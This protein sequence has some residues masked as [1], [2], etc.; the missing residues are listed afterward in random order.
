MTSKVETRI[1]PTLDPD[2]YREIEGLNDETAPF[3]GEVINTYVDIYHVLGKLHDARALA[4]SNP[5][6]TPENRVLVVHREATKHRERVT[7]R[8]ASA[9][10]T[11]RDT[12]TH[13]ES[14]LS[15]P[16]AERAGHGTLNAEV[17]AHVKTM[18]RTAREAFMREAFAKDDEPTLAAILGGQSFLSGLTD[19]DHAHFVREYHSRKNPHL[20]RRLDVMNR[21]L[22]KLERSIPVVAKEFDKAVGAHRNVAGAIAHADQQMHDALKIEPIA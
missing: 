18:T 4:E 14:L 5:A 3:V 6:L 1:T 22:D 17:R 19:I 16:L 20:V 2:T 21:F 12:I 7:A 11:L 8:L 9:E 15:Q 10:R 13:T